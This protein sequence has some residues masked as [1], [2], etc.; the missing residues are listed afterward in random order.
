MRSE[1]TAIKRTRVNVNT[2]TCY[3]VQHVYATVLG[4][5]DENAMFLMLFSLVAV[6]MFFAYITFRNIC[7][8]LTH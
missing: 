6:G 3:N 5:V 1:E 2:E 8:A 4:K 7:C